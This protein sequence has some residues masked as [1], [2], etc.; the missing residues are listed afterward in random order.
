MNQW[1]LNRKIWSI[2]GLL[3][4]AFIAS[5]V[6][7]QFSLMQAQNSLAEIGNLH[8]KRLLLADEIRDGQRRILLSAFE[9]TTLKEKKAIEDE[10]VKFGKVYDEQQERI[11]S[12]LS[13]SSD[14]GKK[15]MD[16]YQTAQ[17]SV[18]AVIRTAQEHLR[19]GE[20]EKAEVAIMGSDFLSF[21]K[22]MLTAVV[23]IAKF[24][25][26]NIFA[27]V[28]DGEKQAKR[29]IIM[30]LAISI[31]S[32]L[33]C[34]LTA[35]FVLRS[36]SRAIA[37]V[38][39]NLADSSVHVSTAANQIATSSESLSQST[40]E[41]AAS[42]EET[43]ASI[44][45][46]NSMIAKNSEASKST[47]EKSNLSHQKAT[48]GKNVVEKMIHSM[49]AIDKSNSTIIAQ[50]NTSN[51]NM[52]NIIKVIEEIG[53]KTKV[54][55]DIVFQTKLLSFNASV[56]A[57][58]AGEHGKGFAVVAEEVGNLAQMSGNAAKEISALLDQSVS[59]VNKIVDESKS[60]IEGLVTEG[61]TTVDQGIRV[62]SQCGEVLNDIVHNVQQAT[63]MA[64]EIASASQEQSRGCAEITK[65]MT[66]LDQMTQQNASTSEECASAAEE[67]SSQ[68]ESLRNLVA[69][70]VLTVN[71]SNSD[72]SSFAGS[73]EPTSTRSPRL[74][75]ASARPKVAKN[76]ISIKKTKNV[77]EASAH[78]GHVVMRS[79]SSEMPQYENQG[80]EEV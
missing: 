74:E 2:V 21:R 80:F 41:Q 42:L 52:V 27:A 13:I 12:L 79:A 57:A 32:I 3:T 53:T 49:T 78:G 58:R 63:N 46:M 76:V 30:S 14:V 55:N 48:E 16:E 7:A 39:R 60:K 33:T 26:D 1:S 8:L 19:V 15:D 65:A 18:L 25:K 69:K 75:T 38:V 56:E 40:T 35:Y 34:L 6:V 11:K 77:K 44:E 70:L 17:E 31:S 36:L 43:A 22:K 72:T 28:E 29:A 64:G 9:I 54:I 20:T 51:E 67:L 50:V 62:A 61:K 23:D 59:T 47:A 37:D 10:I 66:Q 71:G 68:A 24:N 73:S 4:I 5:V 45:E